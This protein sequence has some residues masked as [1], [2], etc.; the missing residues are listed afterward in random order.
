MKFLALHGSEISFSVIMYNVGASDIL[1]YAS[2]TPTLSLKIEKDKHVIV[3][4]PWTLD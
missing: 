1:V 4:S 2:D 3:R